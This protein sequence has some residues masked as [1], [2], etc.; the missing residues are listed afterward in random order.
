MTVTYDSLDAKLIAWATAR[1]A[2][3]PTARA[4]L[5]AADINEATAQIIQL[6]TDEPGPGAF[7]VMGA[8]RISS[9]RKTIDGYFEGTAVIRAVI[10]WPPTEGDTIAECH[11]RAANIVGGIRTEITEENDP[12]LMSVDSE[13]PERRD[14]TDGNERAGWFVAVLTLTCGPLPC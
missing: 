7:V 9:I 11:R 6:D 8:P 12:F 10:E 3:S 14:D 1:L 5:G 2:T 13:V 4:L